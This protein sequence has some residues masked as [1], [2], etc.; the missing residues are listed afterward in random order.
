MRY[1]WDE[2]KATANII[3][4]GVEFEDALE[5]AWEASVEVFDSRKDYKEQR[6]IAMSCIRGR[7]HVLVYTRRGDG[8]RVVSLRK[9]NKREIRKYEQFQKS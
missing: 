8:V 7:L 4:H 9:A 3:K 6:S 5:F 1:E 2:L